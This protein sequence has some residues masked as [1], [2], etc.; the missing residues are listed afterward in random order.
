MGLYKSLKDMLALGFGVLL[1]LNASSK[2]V[3]RGD[4]KAW[5]RGQAYVHRH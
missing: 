5:E 4:P 1:L 2:A 3:E